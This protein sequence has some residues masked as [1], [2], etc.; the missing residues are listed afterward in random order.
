MLSKFLFL[1]VAAAVLAFFPAN[2]AA[3]GFTREFTSAAGSVIEIINEY[4]RVEA[5]ADIEA[6][7]TAGSSIT[8][9]G[10]AGISESDLVLSLNGRNKR[11]EVKPADKKKRID[12]VVRTAKGV[13]LKIRT[14]AGEVRVSGEPAKAA[15]TTDTGTIAANVPSEKLRYELVWTLSKPR[16]V[17]DLDLPETKEL[18]RGR[19]RI[20]GE[21]S[22]NEDEDAGETRL[23][24]TTARGI[25]LLN[26]PP[27]EV[28]DDLRE[29]QLTEAAKALVRSGDSMLVEAVKRV[30]PKQ[31]GEYTGTLRPVK[32][33]PVLREKPVQPNEA[34]E[35]VK[36]AVV[37]VTDAERHAVGELNAADFSVAENGEPRE[38]LS[39]RTVDA[40]FNLVLLL[41]VSG[42]I[43]NYVNFIRKAA[44]NFVDTVGPRDRVAII[45]FNEDVHVISTF[46]TD[47]NALSESLDTF[48]A[49][50]ATALYDALGYTITETLRPLKGERTAIVVLTDGD[51]NRSFLS[52]N[53]LTGAIQESG[54]LIYPLYV[55]SSLIVESRGDLDADI[56]PMRAR[57][58]TLT[59]RSEGEGAKLAEISGGIYYPITRLPQIQAAYDDIVRQLRTSYAVTFRSKLPDT[60]TGVSPRLRIGTKRPGTSV[61]INSIE[62]DAK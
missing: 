40:P 32:R 49:G 44:R 20:K 29:R 58:M 19:Y 46:S 16:V 17:A 11:I 2:A 39:V 22:D 38:I 48:D 53:V 56:D 47:K 57:F 35:F 10:D 36:T 28:A 61:V 27:G 31:F 26:V 15:V 25:V 51:D 50:G 34:G 3:Q 7:D 12:I 30:S 6:E 18:S 13:E 62:T 24:F 37:R 4:G 5:A 55:P 42:S 23:E 9:S 1:I 43:E 21:H 33:E 60:G 8:V 41:D 52:F 59:S 45:T 14:A 54:A